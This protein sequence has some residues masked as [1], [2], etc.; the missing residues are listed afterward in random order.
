M[1]HLQIS[2]N[3]SY[4]ENSTMIEVKPTQKYNVTTVIVRRCKPH[5][6]MFVACLLDSNG[7]KINRK[8]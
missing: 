4:V 8:W 3:E 6:S 7:L 2:E 5:T 1:K